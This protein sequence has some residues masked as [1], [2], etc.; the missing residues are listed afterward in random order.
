M[1]C[2]ID[3]LVRD[4]FALLRGQKV[5]LITNHTGL[6]RFGRSTVSLF[7]DS[8][9]VEL[10]VLFAPEHGIRGTFDQHVAD[11]TDE[12]TG[13]RVYSLYGETR[14]PTAEMLEGVDTLVFDIQDIGTRFYTYIATMGMAMEEAAKRDIRFVVLDRPNP[15]TGVRVFGPMSDRT[16]EF[17]AYHRL[18]LVHGMTVG[19]LARM[20]NEMRK[21]GA[22]LKVVQMEGWKR[23]MWLDETLL[24]WVDPSPNMRSLTQATLY[25][26]IGMIEACNVSV[27]RGT[28]TPFERFG[29]PWID[30]RKL[31]A[32]LNSLGL[33]GVRFLPYRFTPMS[34]KFAGK[35]CGGVQIVLT[36]RNAFDPTETGLTIARELH[37]LFGD[38]FEVKKVDRL[39]ANKL[40]CMQITSATGPKRFTPLWGE[41]LAESIRLRAVFLLY[42]D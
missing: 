29:A 23:S 4:D 10:V 17:T 21:I 32:K 3:V 20:F 30:G 7:H 34:S 2:G 40:V 5:G 18:P 6:D 12:R 16:G 42:T 28:D 24:T 14:R 36:D 13:L 1:L 33:A 27:G 11:S 25:P 41:E 38:A 8:P 39:L 31:A 15:I 19:E 26:A 37:R 22:D 35:E 9:N